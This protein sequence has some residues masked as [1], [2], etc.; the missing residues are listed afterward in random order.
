MK[1]SSKNKNILFLGLVSL[2]TD[3]SSQM[4]YPLIP[5][6]LVS[7]GANKSTIGLI[8]GTAESVASVFRT[9][10]GRWSDRIRKRKLFIFFGYGLSAISKPFLYFANFWTTVL[11]VRF[12]DRMGKA[13]RTPARDALI[14]MSVSP[15]SKG[16]AFGFHRAMDRIGA[17]GGPALAIILLQVFHNDIHLVFLASVI[18]GLIALLFVFY[19]RETSIP[20]KEAQKRR[21]HTG[22]KDTSFKIFLVANVMF[23][24]G[25]SSNA[26]LILKARE[27]G[28]SVALIPAIWIVYNIFCTLSSPVFGILSDRL[29]RKPI[30]LMSFIY[31]AIIYFLFG[32]AESLWMVWMLFGAYGIYYGLSEGVYRAYIADMVDEQNRATAYG[33]FNTAIGL[34]LL[35]ASLIMGVIWDRLGSQWAFFTSASFSLFGFIIFLVSLSLTSKKGK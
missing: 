30:I 16:K 14:S 13:I 31:Y 32:L 22:M 10:F 20:R 8:E 4:V 24:L 35:P 2:F 9:I 27:T 21:E 5:E 29:G 34:T 23:T 17:I 18:P 11:L 28:L 12:F 6:F 26:F 25:N 1:H 19:A 15:Q 7:I 33:I 3:L